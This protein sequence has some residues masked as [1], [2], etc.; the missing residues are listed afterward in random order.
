MTSQ[1]AGVLK[2]ESAVLREGVVE[3]YTYNIGNDALTWAAKQLLNEAK[4]RGLVVDVK[5]EEPVTKYTVTEIMER[6]LKL[7]A[8][9]KIR[10][11]MSDLRA[12]L[13]PHHLAELAPQLP[14]V[15]V[16]LDD[17][18]KA[19]AE[20]GRKIPAIKAYRARTGAG[21]RDAKDAIDAYY[22]E[23]SSKGGADPRGLRW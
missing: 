7:I 19:M 9:L 6:T 4:A 10:G 23:W 20:T 8:E 1:E 22:A 5:P 11:M 3:V 17:A 18:E 13:P 14:V 16:E 21:L 12:K 2:F 15:R